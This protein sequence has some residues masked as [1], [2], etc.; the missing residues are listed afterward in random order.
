MSSSGQPLT[1]QDSLS[2]DGAVTGVGLMV[3]SGGTAI[4]GS[5]ATKPGVPPA[6]PGAVSVD[7]IG[8]TG[9]G[10]RL[11]SS[12][13]AGSTIPGWSLATGPPAPETLTVDGAG[14]QLIVAPAA[15][16]NGM[17]IIGNAGTGSVIV[18]NG[19]SLSSGHGRRARLRRGVVAGAAT[20][21]GSGSGWFAGSLTI[22]QGGSGGI[23]VGDGGVLTTFNTG[24]G[25]AGT[26]D[27]SA[28]L[29]RERRHR[30]V[31]INTITMSG[32]TLDVTQGGVVVISAS[33]PTGAA[34]SV[35]IDAGRV[36]SEAWERSMA[37]SR[38]TIRAQCWRPGSR[39]AS[40]RCMLRVTSAAEARLN[41]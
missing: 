18:R 5:G 27:V 11:T 26:I 23:A 16:P 3:D 39:R 7:V 19:G 28:T 2:T 30:V 13:V 14:S 38:W 9:V 40:W 25:G 32:G 12:R 15:A 31:A 17:L 29:L 37:T 22:G 35:L 33:A 36:L 20:L 24:I 1:I 34:G 8:F 4:V 21:T 41:R 10:T 6:T